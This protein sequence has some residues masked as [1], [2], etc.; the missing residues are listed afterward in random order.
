MHAQ[1]FNSLQSTLYPRAEHFGTTLGQLVQRYPLTMTTRMNTYR[2]LHVPGKRTT[3]NHLASICQIPRIT[4]RQIYSAAD[5]KM[6]SKTA[7]HQMKVCRGHLEST[8]QIITHAVARHFCPVT[9]C[10]MYEIPVCQFHH[11]AAS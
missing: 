1:G 2:T 3:L 8:H 6:Y 9:A 5:F 11:V 4:T 10:Q 7:R